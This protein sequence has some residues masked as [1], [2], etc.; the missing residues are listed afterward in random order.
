[1]AVQGRQVAKAAALIAGGAVVGAG[2]GLLFAPQSGVETR[3]LL[4]RQAKRAQIQ[5]TRFG[6]KVKNGIGQAVERGKA[7]V[8]K[9]ATSMAVQ[10]A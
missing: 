7:L 6:R 5:T 9:E 3:H 1:M 4:R 2:L 8:K 10:A